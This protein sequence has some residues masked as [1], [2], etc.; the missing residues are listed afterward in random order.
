MPPFITSYLECR[1][2]KE[3]S[4]GHP[5]LLCI[6]QVAGRLTSDPEVG[7]QNIKSL[8]ALAAPRIQSI[9]SRFKPP[10]EALSQDILEEHV[11]VAALYLK[12]EVSDHVSGYSCLM[13]GLS[14]NLVV[15]YGSKELF[16]LYLERGSA[17]TANRCMALRS[18]AC[19]SRMD[20]IELSL[21]NEAE[22]VPWKYL[23]M[24][25][26]KENGMYKKH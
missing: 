18:A 14:T 16:E 23:G 4:S 19:H 7:R 10:W 12:N 2:L 5:M 6:R 9:F 3:P 17:H 8:C 20:L 26:I 11:K 22:M 25:A 15:K 21:P 24:I 1:V 13:F